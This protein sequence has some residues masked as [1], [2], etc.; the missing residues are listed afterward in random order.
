MYVMC[1]NVGDYIYINYKQNP[2]SNILLLFYFVIF[3]VTNFNDKHI[4][5]SI[6]IL[7]CV[8]IATQWQ[9]QCQ[10]ATQKLVIET[11]L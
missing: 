7:D 8:I 11:F 3:T 2:I 9:I 4:L 6:H 10:M 5:V 1:N